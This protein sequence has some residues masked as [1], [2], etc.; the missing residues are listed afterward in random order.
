M[1]GTVHI[2]GPGGQMTRIEGERGVT[3]PCPIAKF[4][5]SDVVRTRRLKHLGEIAGKICVIAAVVPPRFSPSWALADLRGSPRPLMAVV[6]SSSVTYLVGFEDD[7]RPWL[8]KETSLIA[9][10]LPSA[11]IVI[12]GKEK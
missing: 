2:F 10:D 4:K 7:E 9:T 8:I 5:V 12:Q 1:S 11:T 3:P 6:G